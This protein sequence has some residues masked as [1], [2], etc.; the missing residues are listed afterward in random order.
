MKSVIILSMFFVLFAIGLANNGQDEIAFREIKVKKNE[1]LHI[2]HPQDLVVLSQ[3]TEGKEGRSVFISDPKRNSFSVEKEKGKPMSTSVIY[4]SQ[5][6]ETITFDDNGD[7]LPEKLIKKEKGKVT[8]YKVE[9]KLI[10]IEKDPKGIK[11]VL[12]K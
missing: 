6:I 9:H 3:P 12:E 2:S 10:L 11:E 4:Q 8:L 1:I 7:G 5:N